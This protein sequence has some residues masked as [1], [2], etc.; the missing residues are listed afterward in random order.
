MTS[1]VNLY[2]VLNLKNDCSQ[3]D[4]KRAHIRLMKKYHPDKKGGNKDMFELVTHA[5]NR[6]SNI[7]YRAEY[8]KIY[9]LSQQSDNTFLQLRENYNNYNRARKTDITQPSK[10]DSIGQFNKMNKEMDLKHN[11]RRNDYKDEQDDPLTEKQTNEMYSDYQ[12]ARETDDIEDMPDEIFNKNNFDNRVFN[13]M[14]DK[15][16]GGERELIPSSSNPDP[17]NMTDNNFAPINN[18]GE[19]FDERSSNTSS[20]YSNIMK[21]RKRIKISKKDVRSMK[22]VSYTTDHNKLSKDY[23]K[24]LEERMKNISMDMKKYTRDAMTLK[25]YTTDKD[26]PTLGGYGI[27]HNIGGSVKKIEWDNDNDDIRRQYNR[28]LDIRKKEQESEFNTNHTS[29]TSRTGQTGQ[30][31]GNNDVMNR[32]NEALNNR[33]I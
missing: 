27:F 11:F 16:S 23:N 20:D 4:I 22:G 28:L 26:D 31:N 15:Y 12:M 7:E 2:D 33:K 19:L 24:T 10:T 14:Y 29:R 18:L 32:Y 21:K 3:Q 30:T 5:Y 13:E 8:D 6:L 25:D 17:Y 1:T 9:N